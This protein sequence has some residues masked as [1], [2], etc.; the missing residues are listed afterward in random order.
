MNIPPASSEYMYQV[1]KNE[2]LTLEIKPGEPMSENDLCK[3]FGVS[4]TPVRSA[5]QR[6][7]DAGLVTIVPYKGTTASLLNFEEIRQLIY[8]RVAVESMV[9]RDFI[10]VPVKNFSSGMIARLGFS[11]ATEVKIIENPSK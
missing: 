3:R 5:L 8:M 11:I 1:L 6:L 10:D 9:L 7:L 2:I 4:R